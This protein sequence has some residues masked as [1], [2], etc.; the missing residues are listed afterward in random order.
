MLGGNSLDEMKAFLHGFRS[1]GSRLLA[2]LL[3]FIITIPSLRR[4]GFCMKPVPGRG[5]G[6]KKGLWEGGSHG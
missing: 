6:K 1:I 5:H 3:C 2:F 4:R